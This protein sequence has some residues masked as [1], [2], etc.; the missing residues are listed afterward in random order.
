MRVESNAT[1]W[2]I[3]RGFAV[4]S[5]KMANRIA[6][7]ILFALPLA[8]LG[9]HSRVEFSGQ[10][11]QELQGE[12]VDVVW[13]NPHPAIFLEV[14]RDNGAVEDWRVEAFTGVR[15]YNRMG[16]TPDLFSVGDKVTVAGRI[17]PRRSNYFLGTNVLLADGREVLLSRDDPARWPGRPVVGTDGGVPVDQEVLSRAA[18]ENFGLFR[19][20]SVG[21]GGR[22]QNFPYTEAALAGRTG[23][24]PAD[25]PIAH[26]EQPGMPVTM[27][28]PLPIRFIDEGPAIMLH[29]V[30]FDTRRTIHIDDAR[31]P[32]TQPPTH[33]GY[34]VGR[35]EGNTLVVET[36]RV[37]YPYVDNEARTPQ[38]DA[39]EILE[40]FALSE[41]QSRVDYRLEITDPVT[42]TEPAM[43]ERTYMAFGEPFD[44][45]DC[46]VF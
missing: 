34:S 21:P 1:L 20:W 41:D 6:V 14:T 16:V 5:V 28:A 23:W 36:T 26:C 7:P 42:F 22:S 10:A 11:I 17:S 45:L 35:W 13:L 30:Y 24:D 40:T 27:G 44:V 39:V 37:N 3:V 2:V 32:A 46:H 19:V 33:L 18:T 9:H 25:N 15:V 12:I 4:L 29:S 43:R 31:D 38:S 8:A